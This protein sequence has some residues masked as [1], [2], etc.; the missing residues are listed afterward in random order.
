MTDEQAGG[1]RETRWSSSLSG[2]ATSEQYE[3]KRAALG[4]IQSVRN[5]ALNAQLVDKS[6]A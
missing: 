2:I 3:T 6:S 1:C 5:N 4:G